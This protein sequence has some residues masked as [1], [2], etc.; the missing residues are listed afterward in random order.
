MAGFRPSN[1]IL[2]SELEIDTDRDWKGYGITNIKEVV[3]GMTQ[4]S[5]V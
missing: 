2:I 3:S 5:I 1:A 4:G